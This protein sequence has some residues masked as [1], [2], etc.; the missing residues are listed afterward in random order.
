LTSRCRRTSG[1]ANVVM[2]RGLAAV[3]DFDARVGAQYGPQAMW[4]L[5]SHGDVIKSILADAAGA[6]LDHF[7]RIVVG[8]ASLSVVSYTDRRPFLV[9]VNDGGTDLSTIVPSLPEHGDAPVGGGSADTGSADTESTNAE[10]TNA[11]STN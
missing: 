6:H 2:A 11:E 10:S 5:V 8:P 9:R 3:R 7:Q 4:A 1:W